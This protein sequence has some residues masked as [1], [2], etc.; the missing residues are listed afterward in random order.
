MKCYVSLIFFL[1][2]FSIQ[3]IK[4]QDY[5]RGIG[6]YP[7]DPKEDFS[8]SM[9]IDNTHYRN[10][11]FL[12]AVYQSS[13]YD[14]NLTGQLITDGI[15][16]TSFPGWIV[17]STSSAGIL[18]KQEREW[19]IDRHPSSRIDIDSSYGWLQIQMAG[20]YNVPEVDSINLSGS[21]LVDSLLVKSWKI[22]ITG[23]VDGVNWDT[24]GTVGSGGLPGDTLTGVA[25]LYSPKNMRVFDCPFKLN[26]SFSFKYYRASL[27]SPNVKTWSIAEFA[28]CKDGKHAKIGGP[29]NF[30]STWMSAGTKT[31]WVY[32]D[33]GAKCKFNK[34]VLYWIRKALQGKIQVS[35]DAANWR[36]ISSL[37][38]DSSEIDSLVF[39]HKIE[40][41]YV[42]VLMNKV[43]SPYGYFLSELQV[44]GTGGPVP[45]EHPEA[46]LQKNGEM[47]LS[48]GNWKLQRESLIKVNG[49]SL[50]AKNYNDSNWLTTTV[51]ATIL[52]SYL[53]DGA[54]PDPN[55]GDNQVL[56]SDSYF[57][58]DFWYRDVFVPPMSYNGKHVFLNFNSIN[59]KADVYLNGQKLGKIEGAF[60]RGRFDVTHILVPGKKNILAVRII[61]NDTPGF[62]TEQ[63]KYTTDANGGQL[64]ADNPTFHAS[65]GW[66]WMPTIRGRN[67]GIWSKVYLSESGSVTI[68]D[69]Y[70]SS[71]LPLPDTSIANVNVEVTL[72]NH[73][74]NAVN[75]KLIGKLGNILFQTPVSLEPLESKT[76]SLNPLTNSALKIKNPK[77]WWPNGYGKQNLYNVQLKFVD[78]NGSVSDVDSFKTGLREMTYS[79][80]GGALRI[81]VN[82]R[83]L[84]PRGG[85]WGFPEDLLR[86]RKREYDIAVRYHKEMNFTMIRNWVG[87]TGADAFYDACDKYGIMIWQDFWLANPYDGPNP[88]DD[89]MFLRNAKDFIEKIRNHPSVALFVGRNEG[90]PPPV[91]DSGLRNYIS[92]LDSG[93]H[94]IS[95]SAAGAVSGGGPYRAM[96]VKFYFSQRATPKLHS[97]IGMPNV[98]N[99]E[100]LIKFIPDSASWPSGKTWGVHDFTL[101]GAQYAES[102][103]NM[104]KNDFGVVDSLKQWLTLAQ[105]INYQGYRAIFEAQSK[106]RMGALLWMS[107]PAWPSMVWQTYDYYF[108]PTGAYFGAKKGC[109][110]LHIQWNPVS[111]SIEVVNYSVPDGNGLE[112][113]MDIL[114]LSGKI[115]LHK[116]TTVSCPE[117]STVHCFAVEYPKNLTSVYF[118]RLILKRDSKII[119]R[120][121]Y[122]HALNN[123][124]LDALT[125]LP[126]V[127]LNI[128]TKS[129]KNGDR[130]RLITTLTNNSDT[131]ALMVRLK[132]IRNKTGDRILPVIYSDN[133]VSIMPGES[134]TINIEFQ[135]EDTRGEDPALVI[136]GLNAE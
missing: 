80:K 17:A 25:R 75:G 56:I 8:P 26:K 66:D 81:W 129:N 1:L 37:P 117:D 20:N 90:N 123:G 103:I 133:Y 13:S 33:L 14:Y 35:D 58:S 24:L 83:R 68:E 57:Y 6:V 73:S 22:S 54:V 34:V 21:V 98:V 87:Q 120:N 86:Y 92:E 124:N 16:D 28:F 95:N 118:I 77:L 32:V 127:K 134:R 126:K 82:G 31:E 132:V 49:D 46:A 5:T 64:G 101:G 48:G 94:Y 3:I 122:W 30:T 2:F 116:E 4:A 11:A 7:G 53:N 111:D 44:F 29:Y 50:S 114:N 18:S 42:R 27:S 45:A 41:R 108:A 121:F 105:W 115:I 63:D 40:A 23:S 112:A 61:K 84:I 47:D 69:P 67:T 119:S 78:A 102:F 135:N 100:S 110:P 85:N 128:S 125:K 89:E 38:A 10:L 104:I 131:P 107:H 136:S 70:V 88:N 72:N 65:V 9:R 39:T 51:P 106:H 60:M 99:Y 76:V 113:S 55:Y 36:D 71:V 43:E 19:A 97:E 15:I 91:I 59:W 12:R 62:V 109:E 130:W 93:I 52:V 96:P 79:E 74:S